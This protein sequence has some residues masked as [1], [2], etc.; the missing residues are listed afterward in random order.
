[1]DGRFGPTWGKA[2]PPGEIAPPSAQV[3]VVGNEKG[4][5]GKSTLAILLSVALEYRGAKVAVIDLDVRQR[6]LGRFLENRRRWL[7]ESRVIAPAPQEYQLS[8]DPQ[9]LARMPPTAA[10][11]LFEEAVALARADA[12]ILIVD[13]PGADT[14]LSRAAHLQ[15]DLLVTPMNDSFI[16]LDVLGEVDPVSSGALRPSHYAR[17]VH[18]ARSVRAGYGLPLDWLV[19]RN[20]LSTLPARNQARMAAGLGALSEHLGFRIGPSLSERVIYRELFPYGLT[21]ADL[22]P[23]ARPGKIA[24]QREAVRQEVMG[25]LGALALDERGFTPNAQHVPVD[26]Q[27]KAAS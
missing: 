20:R 16:D 10:V 3:I 21:L 1:M 5:A 25:L 24:V 8:D 19:L 2:S 6:S 15:A 11:S 7:R 27:I 12:D 22:A 13:T 17:A 14:A 26:I 4:G 18:D 23:G 9:V